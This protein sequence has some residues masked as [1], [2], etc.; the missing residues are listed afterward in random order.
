MKLK[1]HIFRALLG[2]VSEIIEQKWT[3]VPMGYRE[4]F[5]AL[6]GCFSINGARINPCG[7][8]FLDDCSA[9]LFYI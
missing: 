6:A 2:N 3:V 1:N 4:E 8:A 9:Q 5:V 7:G